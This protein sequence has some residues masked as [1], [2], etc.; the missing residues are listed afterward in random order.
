MKSL[1]LYTHFYYDLLY[2][3]YELNVN[4]PIVAVIKLE[5]LVAVEGVA[6]AGYAPNLVTASIH[7]LKFFS[8]NCYCLYMFISFYT[9]Y[10]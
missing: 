4:N 2:K 5:A 6:E 3:L 9:Q 1:R 7:K 8:F 10:K